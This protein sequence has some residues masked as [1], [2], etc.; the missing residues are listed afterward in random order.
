MSRHEFRPGDA[1]LRASASA[2]ASFHAGSTHG[3]RVEC[4][5]G[6]F[7]LPTSRMWNASARAAAAGAVDKSGRGDR[8]DPPAAARGWVGVVPRRHVVEL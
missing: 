4:R 8:L 6:K 7:L 2:G 3:R 1:N 5:A